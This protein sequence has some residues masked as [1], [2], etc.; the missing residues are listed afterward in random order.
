MDIVW[1]NHERP[2]GQIDDLAV[3]R[4]IEGDVASIADGIPQ[5]SVSGVCSRRDHLVRMRRLKREVCR[6]PDLPDLQ[7]PAD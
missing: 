3:E 4:G 5:G 6:I 2:V 7:D 1:V